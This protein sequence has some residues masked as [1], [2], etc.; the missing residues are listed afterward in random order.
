MIEDLYE[1]YRRLVKDTTI[2]D[3]TLLS[4]DYLNHFNEAVMLLD[5]V[6]D[7]PEILDDVKDWRPKSYQQHFGDSN[8]KARDLA[9]ESFVWSP[10]Q[11]RAPFDEVIEGLNQKIAAAV[12]A[13]EAVITDHDRLSLVVQEVTM[14]L[15]GEIDHAG[16][17]INGNMA[18]VDQ[19]AVDAIF[20]VDQKSVDAIFHGPDYAASTAPE[21]D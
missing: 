5:M 21:D 14:A 9:I 20:D 3:V 18:R 8:D 16:A 19:D 6:A 11:F 1:K 17:I 7:M 4:T 13:I 15:R 2:N 12:P 10:K